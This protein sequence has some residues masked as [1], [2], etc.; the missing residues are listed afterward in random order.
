VNENLDLVRRGRRRPW[1]VRWR[2]VHA[3]GRRSRERYGVATLHEDPHVV[4]LSGGNQQKVL[5]AAWLDEEPVACLLEEPTNGVD[6]AAKADI[7]RIV[8][9]L[10]GRG[11]AVLLGSSDV[12]EVVRLADRVVVV[13]SGR[14]VADLPMDR[15]DRDGLVSL[16]AGGES[17]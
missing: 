6:V 1:L 5:L 9:D 11:T 4:T 13:R 15:V 10:A 12:D 16:T 3:E 2:K 14:I 17:T 8:D 7:H